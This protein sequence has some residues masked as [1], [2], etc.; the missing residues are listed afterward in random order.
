MT[1]VRLTR[2]S[3][4]LPGKLAAVTRHWVVQWQPVSMARSSGSNPKTSS[5]TIP[6]TQTHPEL[7]PF[8]LQG[9][10]R[11]RNFWHVIGCDDVNIMNA[12]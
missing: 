2:H 9:R 6:P 4:A 1:A 8:L 3:D 5:S 12:Q 7:S 10:R 11:R